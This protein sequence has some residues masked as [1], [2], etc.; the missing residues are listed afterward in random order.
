[1]SFDW[2]VVDEEFDDFATHP[3]DQAETLGFGR[4]TY[5]TFLQC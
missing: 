2:P 1:V 3:L 4:E 5:A